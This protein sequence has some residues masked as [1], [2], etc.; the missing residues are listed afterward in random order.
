MDGNFSFGEFDDPYSGYGNDFANTSTYFETYQDPFH[1]TYVG[2]TVVWC[3]WAF[4]CILANIAVIFLFCKKQNKEDIDNFVISLATCDILYLLLS[5]TVFSST[6]LSNS[7]VLGDVFCPIYGYFIHVGQILFF[8][9]RTLS[10]TILFDLS[11]CTAFITIFV[12][13]HFNLYLSVYKASF[14]N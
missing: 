14:I 10:L 9:K 4:P 13:Q 12:L 11:L 5:V 6:Y 7:W 3:V 2:V 8:L 1:K